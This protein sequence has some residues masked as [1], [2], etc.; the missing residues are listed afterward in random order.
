MIT[1]THVV[2]DGRII[3]DVYDPSKALEDEDDE[4]ENKKQILRYGL[5]KTKMT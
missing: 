1:G 3:T 5:N 4:Y 2:I